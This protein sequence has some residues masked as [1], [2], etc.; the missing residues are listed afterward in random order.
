MKLSKFIFMVRIALCVKWQMLEIGGMANW[1]WD[2]LT[3]NI[4]NNG[5][6]KKII[7]HMVGINDRKF[8]FLKNF[9]RQ[10]DF[11]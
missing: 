1:Y 11:Q 7:N 9:K 10:I 2:R 6:I 3:L 4:I 5:T 8:R